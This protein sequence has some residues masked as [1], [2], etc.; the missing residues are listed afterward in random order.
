MLGPEYFQIFVKRDGMIP[1]I[2][3][4]V[5]EKCVG[6]W[7]YEIVWDEIAS[8]PIDGYNFY[9]ALETDAIMLKLSI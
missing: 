6:Y 3:K 9:F 2:F 5:E 7:S 8:R 1:N 4:Y